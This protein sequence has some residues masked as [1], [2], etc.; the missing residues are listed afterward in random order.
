MQRDARE[1]RGTRIRRPGTRSATDRSTGR[2]RHPKRGITLAPFEDLSDPRLLAELA[3]EAEEAGWD[4]VFVWDHIVYSPPAERVADPWIALAAMA[5]A[6]SRVRLGPMV[7]PP[8]R[9]RP[10]K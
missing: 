2:L 8:G 9:R 6:T 10:Q 7:T 5:T 3:A 1:G 4:G